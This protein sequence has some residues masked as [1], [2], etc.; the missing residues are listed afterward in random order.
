M[1]YLAVATST[2]RPGRKDGNYFCA[3]MKKAAALWRRAFDDQFVVT[4]KMRRRWP[5]GRRRDIREAL[6]LAIPAGVTVETSDGDDMTPDLNV[7]AVFGH[8]TWKALLAGGYNRLNVYDLAEEI[9]DRTDNVTIVLYCCS[10]GAGR[11]KYK[12]PALTLP[13][14]SEA[15]V[16]FKAGFAM[17]L[18]GALA[19]FGVTFEI[20]AHLT[21]GRA[22][23][24]PRVVRIS[25]GPDE[26]IE[27]REVVPFVSWWRRNKDSKGR[28]NWLT[29]RR[30]LADDPRFRFQF[31]FLT[32]AD[33]ERR[34]TDAQADLF[35]KS[36]EK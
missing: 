6:E 1:T 16:P 33:I 2:N 32:D 21:K 24:N 26:P 11:G 14:V 31:P 10:C 15:E 3:E 27:R 7:F 35:K 5:G 34:L 4:Q 20:L 18:A 30:L 22:A 36:D 8:G 29:W 25:G 19:E 12:T 9:A 13:P 23:K 28:L 17:R